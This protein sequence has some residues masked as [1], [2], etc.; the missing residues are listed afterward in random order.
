[1]IFE[2]G[3]RHY[4]S[5]VGAGG[6]PA[7]AATNSGGLNSSGTSHAINLPSGIAAGNM[8]MVFFSCGDGVTISGVTSGW[9]TLFNTSRTGV[10]LAC[11]YKK[12]AGSDTLTVTTS[13]GTASA[14]T[15]YRITGTVHDVDTYSVY[16]EGGSLSYNYPSPSY[17]TANGA[18][19][20]FDPP[21]V[22]S[23]PYGLANYLFLIAA[24]CG[25]Y[26]DPA[27]TLPAN[28]SNKVSAQGA[29]FSPTTDVKEVHSGQRQ[30]RAS[31]ENPGAITDDWSP[32][33]IAATVCIIPA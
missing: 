19:N 32:N 15:S 33:W 10:R 28:Y 8:L 11:F 20:A 9:S 30:L 17:A 1:M 18:S 5:P 29:S 14:H 3:F 24:G 31:S 22:S 23:L 26:T 2:P 7:V 25:Y 16:Q 12:A 13:A 4:K 21:N 6:F 27:P